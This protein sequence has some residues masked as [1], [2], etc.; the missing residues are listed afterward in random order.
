MNFWRSEAKIFEPRQTFDPTLT[1]GSLCSKPRG[2]LM[3]NNVLGVF[4]VLGLV[5][6][7]VTP[8][9]P[10]GLTPTSTGALAA[11]A[12]SGVPIASPITSPMLTFPMDHVVVFRQLSGTTTISLDGA[13]NV[14]VT[15][16]IV[17][18]FIMPQNPTNTRMRLSPSP[19]WGLY[20]TWSSDYRT[21]TC[22]ASV[23]PLRYNTTYTASIYNVNY[24]SASS[25]SAMATFKT[26]Y[27]VMAISSKR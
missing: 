23:I 21:L 9:Q 2:G 25:Y 1:G 6:C 11:Q 15:T 10:T 12:V 4:A 3:K 17:A 20:C 27:G 13:T 24:L 7:G 16:S 22:S 14:P 18:S 26:Q 5:G 19:S 8:P